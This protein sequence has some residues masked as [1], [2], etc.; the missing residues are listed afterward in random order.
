MKHLRVLKD[1]DDT[2]CKNLKAM[3]KLHTAGKEAC[4]HLS[5]Y[6]LAAVGGFK[7]LANVR[8]R[9]DQVRTHARGESLLNL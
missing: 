5:R 4:K 7:A 3:N 9:V 1:F 2:R 8:P 6:K